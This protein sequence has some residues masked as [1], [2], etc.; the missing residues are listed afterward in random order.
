[1]NFPQNALGLSHKFISEH[2]SP[3][4]VC[5]D[6]TAGRGRDTLFLCQLVG[7]S[8]TVFAFDIQQE[9]VDSTKELLRSND[10]KATV[11][12]N[13]H[14]K[15]DQY[16]EK[17]SVDA[18][19]FNFGWL[20]GGDHTKFSH[21]NTSQIAIEKGLELLKP[22]GVMSLCIYCGKET[23]FEEKET[24]LSFLKTLDQKKY[25]VLLT[26]YINRSGNPPIAVFITKD[27]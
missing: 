8:G 16:V 24:L 15:M 3:G 27:V 4:N 20:P 17:E 23:G 19:M 18:I 1:M 6:A 11:I 25:S 10:K 2:V 21:G 7:E 9:A 5:I 12:L 13:C 26:D 22:G 14:S